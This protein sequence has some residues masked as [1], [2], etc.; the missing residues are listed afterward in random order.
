VDKNLLNLCSALLDCKNYKIIY[1]KTDPEILDISNK[2]LA[3]FLEI[4]WSNKKFKISLNKSNFGLIF[5]ILK[6]AIFKNKFKIITYN[7]KNYCSAYKF[8]TKKDIEIESSIFDLKVISSILGQKINTP[9]DTFKDA[10]LTFKSLTHNK[11]DEIKELY[12]SIHLPLTLKVIPSM[13]NFGI[14]DY[15]EKKIRKSYYEIESQENSRLSNFSCFNSC[16]LPMNMKKEDKENYIPINQEELFVYFDYRNME[17]SIL[18]NLTKD[19]ALTKILTNYQDFYEGLYKEIINPY[20]FDKEKRKK[21]KNIFLPHIYGAGEKLISEKNNIKIETVKEIT[22]RIRDN[23][24]KTFS[25]LESYSNSYNIY[26]KNNF[27]KVRKIDEK[28]KSIN[29]IIQS[30]SSVFCLDKLIDIYNVLNGK[31]I[32]FYIHDGYGFIINKKDIKEKTKI[33]KN[34]L[35][36]ENKKFKGIHLNV[37]CTYGRDLNNMI[38][39][40]F[41]EE[42]YEKNMQ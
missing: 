4:Y 21:M 6:Q 31:Y 30:T 17:V 1:L 10:Y 40:N 14:L 36:E 22:K 35:I 41:E 38:E 33:I 12:T 3:F 37:S 32:N 15:K 39:Y 9:P 42:E 24:K 7:F 23:F 11:W 26:Y 18:E 8:F 28:Y 2:D 5:S 16:F 19:T 20:D 34:I 13:E 29:F 25:W 27:G